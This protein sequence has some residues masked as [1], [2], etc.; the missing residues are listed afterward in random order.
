MSS[1]AEFKD[2]IHASWINNLLGFHKLIGQKWALAPMWPTWPPTQKQ[3]QSKTRINGQ[4]HPSIFKKNVLSLFPSFPTMVYAYVTC[5]NKSICMIRSNS[6]VARW[7]TRR[8]VVTQVQIVDNL[9]C[10]VVFQK[11]ETNP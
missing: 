9:R 5:I 6:Q 1:T 3:Q 4:K 7:V 2:Y 11:R 10:S 8:K